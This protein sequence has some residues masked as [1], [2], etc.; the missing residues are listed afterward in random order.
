MSPNPF[1]TVT[2]TFA[3]GNVQSSFN[4]STGYSNSTG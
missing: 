2:W 1:N 3:S 4:N